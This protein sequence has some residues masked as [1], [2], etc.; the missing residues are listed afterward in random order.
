MYGPLAAVQL[1][2]EA[3]RLQVKGVGCC[4]GW[5][6]WRSC[7][8]GCCCG[9]CW[10]WRRGGRRRGGPLVDLDVVGGI[11]VVLSVD[12]SGPR[13]FAIFW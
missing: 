2:V 11:G 4:W 1:H 7:Q 9:C 13:L 8:S 6:C 12:Q 3:P 10:W 5:C